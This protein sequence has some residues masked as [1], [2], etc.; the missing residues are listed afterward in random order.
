[1]NDIPQLYY[2]ST[3]NVKSND[4]ATGT[5]TSLTTGIAA[6]KAAWGR[7]AQPEASAESDRIR[8]HRRAAGRGTGTQAASASGTGTGTAP[9]ALALALRQWQARP[10]G[11]LRVGPGPGLRLS[12][13]WYWQY[14]GGP[15]HRQCKCHWQCRRAA[16]ASGGPELKLEA[17]F[18]ACC[19]WSEEHCIHVQLTSRLV[20][21]STLALAVW[22]WYTAAYRAADSVTNRHTHARALT[23]G[24]LWPQCKTHVV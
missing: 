2:C 8:P 23:W 21:S 24:I 17:R 3:H 22:H 5:G 13:I 4:A 12:V 1:M 18:G 6:V 7:G 15:R 20:Y 11:R 19:Q 16:A 9:V 14:R 10:G